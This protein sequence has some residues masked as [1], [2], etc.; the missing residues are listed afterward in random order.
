MMGR[1]REKTIL[2]ERGMSIYETKL[3]FRRDW[4]YE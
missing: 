3:F 4:K 2:L 1:A